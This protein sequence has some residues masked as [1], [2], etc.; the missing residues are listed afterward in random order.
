MFIQIQDFGPI[1]QLLP[2]F[3]YSEPHST[4][5]YEF[6]P[7]SGLDQ[8]V[9]AVSVPLKSGIPPRLATT[10]RRQAAS[11]CPHSATSVRPSS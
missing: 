8:Y 9:G 11:N 1:T 7:L 3:T 10:S 2:H 5:S 6:L 4:N